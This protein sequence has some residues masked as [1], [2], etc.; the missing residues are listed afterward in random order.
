MIRYENTDDLLIYPIL[1]CLDHTDQSEHGTIG[2]TT[3]AYNVIIIPFK[4]LIESAGWCSIFKL[5]WEMWKVRLSANT[6]QQ[7]IYS[8]YPN[9]TY[10]QQK[11]KEEVAK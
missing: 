2:R 7:L 6:C 11:R 8:T 3:Q 10:K 5:S 1:K 9:H 4:A